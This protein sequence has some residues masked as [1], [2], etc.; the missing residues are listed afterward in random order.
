MSLQY[1]ESQILKVGVGVVLLSKYKRARPSEEV[2]NKAIERLKVAFP[3][4]QNE[5][6]VLLRER[7]IVN[8][9][10]DER[11]KVAC[12]TIIDHYNYK[13]LTIA[14]I[15]EYD[16]TIQLYTK[17]QRIELQNTASMARRKVPEFS[18]IVI[19]NSEYFIMK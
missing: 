18:S 5:F 1:D 10:C 7:L 6:F 17:S 14:N 3:Y 19:G 8:M 9:F 11:L 2:L 13:T 4:Q 16:E 15:I 12:D